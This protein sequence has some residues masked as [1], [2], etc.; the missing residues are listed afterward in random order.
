MAQDALGRELVGEANKCNGLTSMR[1]AH[2]AT[3][4]F[5]RAQLMSLQ[6]PG[7]RLVIAE[8]RTIRV[9]VRV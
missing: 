1:P 6:T 4:T 3:F 8:K 5:R 7:T 9:V 2:V